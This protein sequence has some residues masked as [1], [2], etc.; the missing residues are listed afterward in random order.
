MDSP[1]QHMSLGPLDHMLPRHY[2]RFVIYLSLKP[3][4]SYKIAFNELQRGLSKTFTQLP[5]L[6][7]KVF[8]QSRTRPDWRP[9]Q[10]EVQYKLPKADDGMPWQLKY[11]ELDTD[12]SFEELKELGFPADTFEDEELLWAPFAPDLENGADVFIAQASFIPGACILCASVFHSVADG[13]ADVSIFKIW[14]DHCQ[15]MP[16]TGTAGEEDTPKHLS[17]SKEEKAL[18]STSQRISER[19]DRVQQSIKDARNKSVM[20]MLVKI[21]GEEKAMRQILSATQP[22]L[23]SRV[24]YISSA[25][26][27]S[28]KRACAQGNGLVSGNDAISALLWRALIKARLEADKKIYDTKVD[29]SES[30]LEM[31]I[32]GRPYLEFPPTYLG[33]VV[34]LCRAKLSSETLTSPDTNVATVAQ[35]LRE[36]TSGIN[37]VTAL[38]AYSLA[39]S[40]KTY[41]RFD[42]RSTPVAGARMLITSLLAM[43]ASS[44][45]FGDKGIF[46]NGGKAEGIRPLMGALNK[47]FR[48]CFVMPP[49]AYGGIEVV[50]NLS[51]AEL[52]CLL[53]DKEFENYALH[54]N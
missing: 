54:V 19:S 9:G 20:K 52:D 34:L 49:T 14:A 41:R 5:W 25:N 8:W 29:M 22:E 50:F 1:T 39:R 35:T 40:L 6:N 26:F 13:M 28:L 17:R 4:V 33:N 45:G 36:A 43:P 3:G 30:Q 46:G 48:I 2:A 51:D 31:T 15:D 37:S 27:T 42:E 10:L 53:K 12:L 44:M 32:D 16:V 11:K 23:K 24:F 47:Y 7:G 21:K 18:L 38:D